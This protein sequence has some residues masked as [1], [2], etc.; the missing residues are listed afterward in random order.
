MLATPG[1]TQE[2]DL[3]NQREGAQGRKKRLLKAKPNLAR[4]SCTR[5][6][7]ARHTFMEQADMFSDTSRSAQG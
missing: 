4:G 5:T 1:H 2:E 7:K 6:I 3:G